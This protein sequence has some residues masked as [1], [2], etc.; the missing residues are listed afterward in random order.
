MK[1]VHED[2]WNDTEYL[3]EINALRRACNM[4]EIVHKKVRCERR[5]QVRDHLESNQ[6][7][8]YFDAQFIGNVRRERFCNR[9]RHELGRMKRESLPDFHVAM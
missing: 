7:Q 9:C 8:L 4:H 2:S 1:G 3:K 5:Y 6:C